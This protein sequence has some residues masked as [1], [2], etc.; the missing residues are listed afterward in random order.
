M[1]AKFSDI[2]LFP[3]SA[4]IEFFYIRKG[5]GEGES[6]GIDAAVYQG[7][8]DEGIVGAGAEAEG[9]VSGGS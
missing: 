1:V 6:L 3:E 8:E 4:L 7:I 5:G 2:K 9:K